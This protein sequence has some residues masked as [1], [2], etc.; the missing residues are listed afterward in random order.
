MRKN[1]ICYATA[2]ALV[3][4]AGTV[5]A[6][7]TFDP[8]RV[9]QAYKAADDGMRLTESMHRDSMHNFGGHMER[10]QEYFRKAHDELGKAERYAAQRGERPGPGA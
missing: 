2:L 8:L 7:A 10:A 5:V 1:A 6:Q 3:G 4:A 9:T